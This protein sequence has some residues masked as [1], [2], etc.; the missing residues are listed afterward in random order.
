MVL[1]VLGSAAGGG[2]PQWNCACV[3]CQ[4]LRSGTIAAKPRTQSQLALSL[5][6]QSWHLLNASPDL[7]QQIN[8]YSDLQPDNR[9]SRNSPI[10]S[11]VL[12]NADIDHTLGLLLLRESQPL[13]IYSTESVR[14]TVRDQNS[15]FNM[16]NQFSGHTEWN[17]IQPEVPFDLSGLRCVAVAMG[18]RPPFWGQTLPE[19]VAGPFVI[20]LILEDPSKKTRVGYFPGVNAID[21]KLMVKLSECDAIFMDGTFWDE[22]ELV[23]HRP[24][25]RTARQ[26]QH[27]PIS[28]KD[29]SL[30]VFKHLPKRTKKFFIHINNTNPILNEKSKEYS[31]VREFGWD[32]AYDG[33]EIHL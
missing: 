28:G 10:K 26:M 22:E 11:V 23:R 6:G 17:T 15:Y 16:L 25:S 9:S 21:D 27:I 14:A 31:S 1:R 3:N 33:M 18:G 4:G 24:G 32:I 2:F 30:E 19:S 29:G 7:R 5:D 13:R 8:A 20:G 12:T